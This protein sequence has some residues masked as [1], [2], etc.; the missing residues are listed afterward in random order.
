M[1]ILRT[2]PSRDLK[3]FSHSFLKQDSVRTILFA[4]FV[5]MAPKFVT[6]TKI[7]STILAGAYYTRVLQNTSELR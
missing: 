7:V 4:L 6:F 1:F 2:N 5:V 3:I